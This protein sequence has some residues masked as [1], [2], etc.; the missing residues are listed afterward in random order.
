MI[1]DAELIGVYGMRGSGKST[2]TKSLVKSGHKKLVAF[3]TVGEYGGRGWVQCESMRDVLMAMK[4]RWKHGFKISYKPTAGAH[5]ECLH[6]LATLCFKVQQPYKEDFD[7]RK[8]MMVVEEAN[9]SMPNQQFSR[10]FAAMQEAILQGRHFGI[11]C[12]GVSQRPALLSS[13]FRANTART[14]VF[15]LNYENDRIEIAKVIGRKHLPMLNSMQK[16]EFI[17]IENGSF[18]KGKTTVGGGVSYVR[19]E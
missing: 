12:I 16:F 4:K 17:E 14:Y 5:I 18:R 11:E 13:D 6:D 10:K 15:Q 2:L 9:M 8:L 3:D 7:K 19:T 1:K